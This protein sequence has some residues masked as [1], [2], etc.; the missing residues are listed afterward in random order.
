MSD[1]SVNSSLSNS[2]NSNKSRM[3]AK[4][5]KIKKKISTRKISK[6]FK[7]NINKQSFRKKLKANYLR[8]ICSDSNVCMAFG[9]ERK[10]ILQLFDGFTNFDH[11]TS[12]IRK[13]GANSANGFIKEIKYENN[14]YISYAVLKS[15]VRVDSDNL[16]YEYIVGLFINEQ[17]KK[18]PCFIDTY[19]LYYYRDL[20]SWNTAKNSPVMSHDTLRSSLI[21]EPNSYNYSKMCQQSKSSAILIE[22]L[23]NVTS[24]DDNFIKPQ[25]SVNI[26]NFIESKLLYI[27]YQVYMPLSILA[28]KFTHYDLHMDNILLY[29]PINGKHIEY[30]YHFDHGI[31]NFKSEYIVK[32]I[33]YGRSYYKYDEPGKE[34]SIDIY[35][36]LC[37]ERDC[38]S[39]YTVC[40]DDYGLAWLNPQLDEDSYFISSSMPNQSHDLRLITEIKRYMA[41]FDDTNIYVKPIYDFINSVQYGVG[42][43]VEKRF[44][45]EPNTTSGL[46]L[47]VN[48]VT[49]AHRALFDIISNN[50]EIRDLNNATYL[51]Q[52]KIGDFHIFS[53]GSPMIFDPVPKSRSINP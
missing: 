45:T 25:L 10:R 50:T 34:N 13:I 47:H 49:D 42:I 23:K 46:P 16:A 8:V 28:D 9:T 22:H 20:A 7:K 32:L 21:I 1:S 3:S 12:P 51:P 26:D 14:G 48:N 30:N 39:G 44:G 41:L 2:S 6:F 17:S 31:I 24:L 36:K 37:K 43:S 15:S 11:V 53:D 33:D 19:G 27:L 5:K 4:L 29:K 40:G 35:N 38:N 52:N 18:F